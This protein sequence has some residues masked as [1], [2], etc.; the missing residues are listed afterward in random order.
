MMF[1]NME[2]I[3]GCSPYSQTP[4]D[5]AVYIESLRATFETARELGIESRTLHEYYEEF[6]GAACYDRC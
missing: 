5:V 6:M 4:E 2:L 3:P 1:H